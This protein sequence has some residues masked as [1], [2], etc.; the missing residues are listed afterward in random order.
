MSRG[1]HGAIG[2]L[3]ARAPV[4]GRAKTRLAAGVGPEPAA[5]LAAAAL[6]DTLEVLRGCFTTVHVSLTG[7][8]REAARREEL[9]AALMGCE[10]SEQAGDGF[11][12]RLARAHARAARD[13]RLVVQVGMD[14]PQLTP[15]LLGD[16]VA[17]AGAADR[18]AVLGPADDGGWWVLALRAP[19]L[20]GALVEVPMSTDTTCH[21]TRRALQD[22]GADVRPAAVLRDVDELAD[23][24]VVASAAPA[25][26]FA[27]AW[28]S[29][30]LVGAG[31]VP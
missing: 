21:D 30:D 20:A 13:G 26:R 16:V 8:L 2:L 3:V 19:A 1:G 12:A 4:P 28:H 5:D 22:Q 6:L 29:L 24:A 9:E 31:A 17:A 25:T 14:T 7:D 11:G 15:D 10:V 18:T 27:R 23:A